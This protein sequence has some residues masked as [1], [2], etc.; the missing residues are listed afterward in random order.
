MLVFYLRLFIKPI[1]PCDNTEQ[2]YSLCLACTDSDSRGNNGIFTYMIFFNGSPHQV[3]WK[4]GLGEELF[5]LLKS[6]KKILRINGAKYFQFLRFENCAKNLNVQCSKYFNQKEPNQFSLMK[7]FKNEW[8]TRV[9][10]RLSCIMTIRLF[11]SNFATTR[12]WLLYSESI[13]Q[14]QLLIRNRLSRSE[15][16]TLQYYWNQGMT[17][18]NASDVSQNIW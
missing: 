18:P 16:A 2:I 8:K 11:K 4:H 12:K 9:Q 5:R 7:S 17:I 10:K 3:S 6:L 1:I 15:T 13:W 14:P